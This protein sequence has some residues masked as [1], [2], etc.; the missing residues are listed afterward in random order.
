MAFARDSLLFVV[1]FSAYVGCTYSAQPD[2][3]PRP[4]GVVPLVFSKEYD[5]SFFGIEKIH[6]FDTKKYG[7]IAR[8][9]ADAFG[10]LPRDFQCPQKATDAE[11]LSIHTPGYLASLKK[12]SVVAS[13][14]EIP[15]LRYLPNVL[16]QRKMLDAMRYATGGTVLG[17]QLAMDN[18]WAINLSGGYHHAKAHKGEGFCFFADIPL[19]IKKLREKQPKLKVLIVDLDAHQGNG[20]EAI[21][22]PDPLTFIFDM[23]SANNYP[24]DRAVSNY[25]DFNHPLADYIQDEDYLTPLKSEL[26]KAIKAV[27][28]DLI[29]YNA[30]TDIFERDPLGKM[31]VTK[32]GII[33]RDHFLFS[34]AF[35]NKTPILMVLSG[36]Y[37]S[38][39]ADIV[40]SSIENVVKQFH[41]VSPRKPSSKKMILES[42]KTSR[43]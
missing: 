7:K 35:A 38:Q 22:G 15:L 26:P 5:I 18:G 3:W 13:I 32:E 39:S 24:R 36:G 21:S 34:Q 11:L 20:L 23:Y 9:L 6:P 41:L 16:L 30:G 40:G 33:E 1:L 19:A 27:Q 42:L 25:I 31:R 8:H 4:T 43:D 2:T 28:P 14:A 12:S 29:I 37:S 10:L 17:A